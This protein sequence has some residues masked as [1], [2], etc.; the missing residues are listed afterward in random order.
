MN[1]P[2]KQ[3]ITAS[4]LA[5]VYFTPAQATDLYF[6]LQAGNVSFGAPDTGSGQ[7]V[8]AFVGARRALGGSAGFIGAELEA[9]RVSGFSP[10]LF[11]MGSSAN[12][13]QGEVHLGMDLGQVKAYGLI[14]YTTYDFSNSAFNSA[15]GVV[16]GAG[17]EVA[18]SDRVSLRL[19]TSV[20]DLAI[21][22]DCY[23]RDSRTQQTS[24]GC[25]IK[26]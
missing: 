5:A 20:S 25:V 17:L 22:T 24:L 18:V 7:N 4:I 26:F 15:N 13:L 23:D 11:E 8:N 3:V 21:S 16:F 9:G 6:G 12:K 10:A 14:G 19:E 2:I 1:Y